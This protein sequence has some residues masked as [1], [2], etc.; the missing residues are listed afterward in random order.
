MALVLVGCG[1]TSEGCGNDLRFASGQ[2]TQWANSEEFTLEIC[3]EGDCE[4]LNVTDA[5]STPWFGFPLDPNLSGSVQIE[6]TITSAE[7]TQSATGTIEL[8]SYRPNGGLCAPVC[9][10][11]DVSIEEGRLTNAESG[12]I[13]PRD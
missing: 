3:A 2:L 13:P 7:S 9:P 4:T 6:A 8:D 12:E 10:G 5:S 1:C 11:A